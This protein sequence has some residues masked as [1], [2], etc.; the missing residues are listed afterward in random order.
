M[1]KPT[2]AQ[3]FRGQR[4]T[5]SA[6][7]FSTDSKR[8]VSGASDGSVVLWNLRPGERAFR[9]TGHEVRRRDTGARP[10]R[11]SRPLWPPARARGPRAVHLGA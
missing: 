5:V 9:Y 2:L 6:L 11:S 4:G 1:A 7:D 3:T 8:L 10:S